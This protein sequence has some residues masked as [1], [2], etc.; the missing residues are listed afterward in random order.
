MLKDQV[1]ETQS[2]RGHLHHLLESLRVM[3][4]KASADKAP[5]APAELIPR[6]TAKPRAMVCNRNISIKWN[7][8]PSNFALF[9]TS[10]LQ[11]PGVRSQLLPS[12]HPLHTFPPP[13]G[14]PEENSNSLLSLLSD[15]EQVFSPIPRFSPPNWDYFHHS[16]H[17]TVPTFPCQQE[18][19]YLN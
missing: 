4:L 8:S 11:R 7:F 14:M 17:N 19:D 12:I 2:K 9:C 18:R 13:T 16:H 3:E 1:M 5:Q 10:A 6:E 15:N